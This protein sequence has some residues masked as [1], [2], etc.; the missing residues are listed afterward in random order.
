MPQEYCSFK[1]TSVAACVFNDA[2]WV[3]VH[4][5]VDLVSS[6][7]NVK[8]SFC[9]L[10]CI[11]GDLSASEISMPDEERIELMIRVKEGKISMHDA[12]ERVREQ[13]FYSTS[14][15]LIDEV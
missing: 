6:S 9:L 10:F 11:V 14:G 12:V 13:Y 15:T 7:N 4:L 1:I 8:L 5:T 2:P 3:S